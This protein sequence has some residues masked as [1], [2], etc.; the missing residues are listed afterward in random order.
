MFKFHFFSSSMQC[1]NFRWEGIEIKD[2][3]CALYAMSINEWCNMWN[4]PLTKRYTEGLHICWV[5]FFYTHKC[6]PEGIKNNSDALFQK[7]FWLCFILS[8]TLESFCLT[9]KFFNTRIFNFYRELNSFGL[10]YKIAC[11]HKTGLP[12]DFQ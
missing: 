9:A 3:V 8:T 10:C 11:F 2:A 4:Y 5:S 6:W 7:W 1:L 12:L